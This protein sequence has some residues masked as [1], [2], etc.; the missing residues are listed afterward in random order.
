MGA[1]LWWGEFCP[2]KWSARGYG[3]AQGLWLGPGERSVLGAGL[4]G[5]GL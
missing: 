1:C 5:V 3:W 4:M 2:D